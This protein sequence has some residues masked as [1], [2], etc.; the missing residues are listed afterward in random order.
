MLATVDSIQHSLQAQP[1]GGYRQLRQLPRVHITSP[2]LSSPAHFG[3]TLHTLSRAIFQPVTESYLIGFTVQD[4][5]GLWFPRIFNSLE[6]GRIRYNP[7]QDPDTSKRT[8]SEQRNHAIKETIKGLN[9]WNGFE[10]TAREVQSGPGYL[11]AQS[12]F[13]GIATSYWLG[14][15]G[16]MMSVKNL[17]TYSCHLAQ[18]LLSKQ[19]NLNSLNNSNSQRQIL[20]KLLKQMT[21]QLKLNKHAELAIPAVLSPAEQKMLTNS[22]QILQ[23]WLSKHFTQAT[24]V[25]IYD[26]L[27]TWQKQYLNTL[28]SPLKLAEK[29]KKLA[30]LEKVFEEL[31]SQWNTKVKGITNPT[32]LLAFDLP[33]LPSIIPNK[34]IQSTIEARPFLVNLEKFTTVIPT[35]L[36]DLKP[37]SQSVRSVINNFRNTSV[38]NKFWV[39]IIATILGCL[40]HFYVSAIAQSVK[41]KYPANR[42][43]PLPQNNMVKHTQLSYNAMEGQSHA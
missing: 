13:V 1:L 8:E 27:N 18:V 6:R 36:K 23:S 5:I 42:L 31:V 14:R 40:N 4:V 28:A 43:I 12:I 37:T 16:L 17:D 34:T 10:E 7:A 33:K 2:L 39:C 21:S 25:R 3:S 19:I 26:A 24:P 20:D 41:R 38:V 29:S 9:W 30:P 11:L 35:I 22:E 15:R 32:Q